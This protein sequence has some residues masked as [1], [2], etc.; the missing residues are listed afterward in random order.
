M[1]NAYY[2]TDVGRIRRH[3]EDAAEIF[4]NP[5]CTIMV[6]ADGMGGHAAGEVASEMVISTVKSYFSDDLSFDSA[7]SMS[8]WSKHVL[9]EVNLSIF[10]YAD[11]HGFT[12]G[13]GTTVVIAIITDEVISIAHVGDSRTYLVKGHTFTQIT[14]DHSLVQ[15]LVDNG[16]I[17]SEEARNHPQKN[18]I[19]RVVGYY[20]EVEPDVYSRK[21]VTVRCN[22]WLQR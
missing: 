9:N 8:L 14:K 5:H 3:N 4:I 16:E 15:Q 10:N 13:M 21:W 6:I 1:N 18:V 20:A 22:R 7:E 19:T 11:A 17:T 2:K 12:K